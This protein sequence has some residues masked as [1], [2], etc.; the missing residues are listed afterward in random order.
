MALLYSPFDI[1]R[2]MISASNDDQVFE[3]SG[4]EKFAVL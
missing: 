4:D 3:A 1:L 2:V